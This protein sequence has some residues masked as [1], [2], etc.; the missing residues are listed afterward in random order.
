MATI[1]LNR[2]KWQAIVRRTGYPQQSK[3][4]ISKTDAR[5]W[6]R[7]TEAKLDA[8]VMAITQNAMI[9]MKVN[10]LL[11][12]YK[13]TVTSKK[14]GFA[15]EGK[16]IEVFLRYSWAKLRI[17]AITPAIFS[18][19]RDLRLTQVQP[20]TVRRELGLLRAIF[21]YGIREWNIALK[22]NPLARIQKPRE[23][24]ARQRRLEAGELQSILTASG[25]HREP[26]LKNGI[27]L[28]IETGMR[29]G[30]LLSLLWGD[31]NTE[32]SMLLIRESKNG[33]SRT[34][35]LSKEAKRILRLQKEESLNVGK[36]V[37]PVSP[38]AFQLSWQRCKKQA[39]KECQSV[40]DLR[41]H[42]LRHEAI[43]RFFELGLSVPE[44]A[45]ISGHKDVRM[46]FRYTH[47]RAEDV[48]G[49]LNSLS[50]IAYPFT[51]D[52]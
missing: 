12:K 31:V 38:N 3:S 50:E 46:L 42:D 14:K 9:G 34:I 23:P 26:W 43:S 39:V 28:A 25:R 41:F 24:Q 35:P 44:V 16:R 32:A 17:T 29:R 21:E 40:F 13:D 49:K 45:L 27:L 37:F 48:A 6:A 47:L 36:L 52:I 10:E 15:S 8:G 51:I 20:A 19:F 1:R 30:E 2:N 5:K 11:L 18:A 7:Q 22:E 33:L 4:F